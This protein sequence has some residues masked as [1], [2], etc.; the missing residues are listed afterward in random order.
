MHLICPTAPAEY[1]SPKGWTRVSQNSPTGKSV[2]FSSAPALRNCDGT[3]RENQ[4]PL[5][6]APQHV[7][8]ADSAGNDAGRNSVE[9]CFRSAVDDRDNIFFFGEVSMI[10]SVTTGLCVLA[11]SGTFAFAQSSQG[12]AAGNTGPIA[13]NTQAAPMNS[14]ARMMKM[15]K[16][17]MMKRGMM[18]KDSGMSGGMSK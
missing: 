13:Q 15:K 9:H 11:L 1:F 8:Y 16:K 5:G 17:K 2:G 6:C 12:P 14:N 7:A 10:K 4:S 3:V 18:K